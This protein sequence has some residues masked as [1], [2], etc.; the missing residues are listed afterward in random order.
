VEDQLLQGILQFFQ[1]LQVQV[2]EGVEQDVM[3]QDNLEDLVQVVQLV[4][5]DQDLEIHPL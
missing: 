4:E 5:A 2:V 1:Q 3:L